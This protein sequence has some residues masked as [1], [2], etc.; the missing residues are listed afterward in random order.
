[1]AKKDVKGKSETAEPK[2]A[3][4]KRAY[5]RYVKD[6]VFAG[7]IVLVLLMGVMT[8]YY[9]SSP[10]CSSGGKTPTGAATAT[11]SE[12][13]GGSVPSETTEKDLVV[14][15]FSEFLCPYC[16]AAAGFND[17]LETR[18][19][20]QNPNWEPAVP[21]I[22]RDYA[23]T[24]DVQFKHYIIHG[25]SAQV[26]AEASECARDQGKFWEM[27]DLMFQNQNALVVSDLKGYAAELGMDT[28]KFNSCLDNG[29]KTA[30]VEADSTL[31]DTYG[32]SGTPTF[33]IL[34][35]AGDGKVEDLGN[36][37]SSV[38]NGAIELYENG[39]K[40]VG[41]QPYSTL[42]EY[43][44]L[45]LDPQ[46][47]A[48]AIEEATVAEQARL[49]G[50]KTS[51]GL[52][53]GDNKPQIDFFV[54][55]YCPYGNIAEEAIEP[56]YQNLKD[57]A[58]FVPHYIVSK[59]GSAYSSLHGVQEFNQDIRELCVNKYMGIEAYFKF[60]LAMNKDCTSS[61]AD[62]CWEN[63]AKGLS[64]DVAKIKTCE[65]GEGSAIADKEIAVANALGVSGSPTVYIEGVEYSGGRTAQG[66]QQV[67]CQ[68]FDTA[69]AECGTAL[70]NEAQA[71]AGN[72]G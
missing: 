17:A 39:A 61:N 29:D 13:T 48:A 58:L 26:A 67:L 20:G 62:T 8:V 37:I 68:G 10:S 50:I 21:G 7:L 35:S 36:L 42:K 43:I 11:G 6:P 14:Y 66:Y 30:I 56:V 45:E 71:A 38:N 34:H 1:M 69:P 24:V 63:V 33:V 22:L 44:D 4:T 3:E 31:A 18:F 59:S 55:S 16:G 72:C 15:T 54:M 41:A 70:S 60:V 23:D 51:L 40:V 49:G 57:K 47:K 12:P 52:T 5:A 9:A 32:V 2:A 28:T 19:K 53:T 64:L 25:E 27:H 65:S 46:K